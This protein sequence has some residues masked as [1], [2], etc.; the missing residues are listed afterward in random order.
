MPSWK[1]ILPILESTL[2]TTEIEEQLRR[3]AGKMEIASM[4]VQHLER[5][6]KRTKATTTDL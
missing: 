4:E 6:L 2:N 5:L 3:I 1:P